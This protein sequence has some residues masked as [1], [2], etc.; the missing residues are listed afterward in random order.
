MDPAPPSDYRHITFGSGGDIQSK[1]QHIS[2]GLRQMDAQV[3]RSKARLAESRQKLK[4][5]KMRPG[6]RDGR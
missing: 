1:S 5:F 3:K 4:E 6:R 2:E